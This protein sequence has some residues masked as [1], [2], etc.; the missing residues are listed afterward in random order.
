[1]KLFGKEYE[2]PYYRVIVIFGIKIRLM[3]R[4]RVAHLIRDQL[5]RDALP[6]F[7]FDA[8][9]AF[10]WHLL[11]NNH[12]MNLE[13][14]EIL[15]DK[16]LWL[17]RNY[18]SNLPLYHRLYNKETFKDWMAE[19][20]LSGHVPK[21]YGAWDSMHDV[22]WDLLPDQFVIKAV[23][24]TYG[25]EVILV[26]NKSKLDMKAT[27]ARMAKWQTDGKPTRIMAEELLS[28]DTS[29][30]LTDYKFFCIDGKCRFVIAYARGRDL[31]SVAEKT[32][33]FYTPDWEKGKTIP[34]RVVIGPARAQVR[35]IPRPKHLEKMLAL[36]EKLAA[37]FP[38]VRVDLYQC[39]DKIYVGEL[40]FCPAD[41]RIRFEPREFDK[42]YGDMCVLPEPL[43]PLGGGG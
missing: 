17:R 40:T 2:S 28:E 27:L 5:R 32:F 34:D 6:S 29:G 3:R 33:N 4:H 43:P 31:G 21:T 25:R 19:Q 11:E 37:Y 15:G 20:G 7:E 23:K 10:E 30:R 24:G 35:D 38:L 42:I 41:G 16:I 1:M 14:P 36:S 9:R 39:G 18:Y 8:F 26:H 13:R 12:I 22:E